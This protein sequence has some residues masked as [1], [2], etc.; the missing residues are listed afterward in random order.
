MPLQ[1]QLVKT[2]CPP[3]PLL[4]SQLCCL[5]L[6]SFLFTLAFQGLFCFPATLTHLV[7]LSYPLAVNTA[8]MLMPPEIDITRQGPSLKW[9]IFN[10]CPKVSNR[11]LKPSASST[12]SPM[13]SPSYC[14]LARSLGI[15]TDSC[16]EISFGWVVNT[17]LVEVLAA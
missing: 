1:G 13:P 11:Y 3:W 16:T 9:P 8:Y 15:H 5:L 14:T 12:S 7:S 17:C 4:P 10:L 2:V 6:F